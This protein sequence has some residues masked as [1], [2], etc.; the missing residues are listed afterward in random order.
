MGQNKIKTCLMLTY[1]YEGG[2]YGTL[3]GTFITCLE[4]SAKYRY[5]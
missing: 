5:Q 1:I 3:S 2:T 4:G